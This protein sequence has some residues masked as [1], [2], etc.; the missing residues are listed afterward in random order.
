LYFLYN[1]VAVYYHFES[2]IAYISHIIGFSLGLPLGISWSP[3]WKKN[4]LISIGLLVAY[5]ALVF[6][7][8][9]YV[10]PSVH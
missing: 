5:P 1:D 9:T 3:Q 10:L 6:I 8:M 2:D 7:I 4:L